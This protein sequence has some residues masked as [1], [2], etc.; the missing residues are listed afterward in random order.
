MS[1]RISS[2]SARLDALLGGG[3]PANAI[4]LVIGLPG[5]GKTILAQQ[6]MFHNATV[7]R[8]GVY[9]STVSEPLEK[10]LR[11]GQTLAFFDAAA[12]G[13]RV[14]YDGLGQVVATDGLAGVVERVKAIIR[15][16][17]PGVLAIDSFKALS[18]YAEGE[19]EFRRFLH[20]LA[21]T[22]SAFPVTSIWIGEYGEH[23]VSAAP[24]FAVADGIISMGS[25]TVHD[26]T[27]RALQV[28]KLRGSGF[29][30]GRHAYR[31]SATGV[32]V[33]PRLADVELLAD[34]GLGAR[35]LSS[36]IRALDA[37]L[38]DGY[39]PGSSTLIA[40]PTGIGKTLMGLH[41]LFQGAR[42]GEPGVIATL[43]EDPSQLERIVR[44]FGWSLGDEGVHVL[45]RNP[46][47]LYV[48]EWVY[49]LFDLVERVGARR[50]VVDSLN[51]LQVAS[52]DA[53]RFREYTYSLLQRCSRRGISLLMT[54][55][56]PELFGVTRLSEFG[57]SHLADNVVVLQYRGS[58]TV[59]RRALTVLKTRA[60]RHDPAVREF[61][62]TS[63]GI[64]LVDGATPRPV[65]T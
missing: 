10:I 65:G 53:T 3:L 56:I 63:Q 64:D 12:V 51:D 28:L 13:H 21:G 52:P 45:A 49:E 37:M 31:L 19:G 26:R 59:V 14:F 60:S 41:F 38:A 1:G 24:E 30:S 48:D 43:Q 57:A 2:G 9:L 47:D 7:E 34:Y 32:D 39:W 17:R 42:H 27:A 6:C 50:V 46:V 54:Y 35:R 44:G 23:E 25:T 15:E 20:D 5:A 36:G 62:I 4:N 16:R 8:P 40:G 29:L 33:F 55:E 11:Y 58:D 18:P 61:E 22:L